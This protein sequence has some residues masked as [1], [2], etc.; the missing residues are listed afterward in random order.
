MPLICHPTKQQNNAHTP[1]PLLH[2]AHQVVLPDGASLVVATSQ[3][4]GV[5]GYV[6]AAL[7]FAA[8]AFKPPAQRMVES[9]MQARAQ[10]RHGAADC[11]SYSE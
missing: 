9:S 1:F 11:F 7:A 10:A 3:P 6:Q 5:E 2:D 4:V 8:W